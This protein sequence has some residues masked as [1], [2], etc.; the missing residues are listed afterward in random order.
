MMLRAKHLSKWYGP[1]IG[2]NNLDFEIRPGV[3]GFLGPNGAGKTTVLKL[4]TG[5]LKPSQGELTI[6]DQPVW[7]QH[8]IMKEVGYCPEYDA[9]W[10]FLTGWH[11]V[12]SLTQ[13]HGY[14]KEEAASRTEKAIE[15]M[16]MTKAM[17]RRIAGYSKGMRQRIK[18]A[19]AIAHDPK[20][21]FL[22]EP[23][24]GMDPLA[25]HE[26][27]KMIKA[28][29]ESGKIVVVSSHILHEVEAMTDNIL[30]INH[31]RLLAQ[32]SIYEIRRLLDRHPLQITIECEDIQKL[33]TALLQFP[34]I[35]GI[36][37]DRVRQRITVETN[38]P[39]AF[40]ER[41]PKLVLDEKLYIRSIWSPDEN[42]EAVF[43]YLVR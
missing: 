28:M 27:V 24:N 13:M 40:H 22:D 37:L 8:A 21:L 25:R 42:L 16:G 39:D 35:L 17:H 7:N 36:Q 20:I 14:S 9:F 33:S 23:L 3:T 15:N 31:G 12:L 2:V 41:F 5:Q 26:T 38:R 32:G 18:L 43:D 6:N 19:Q 4:M 10:S 34:D 11:F 29:G 30:L 1:V